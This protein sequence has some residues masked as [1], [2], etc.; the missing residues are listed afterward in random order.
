VY[1]LTVSFLNLKRVGRQKKF[2]TTADVG[3]THCVF[4]AHHL[5]GGL[6][7]IIT[8]RTLAGFVILVLLA[9][10]KIVERS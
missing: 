7:S 5:G 8:Y 2:S 1:P 10:Q 3:N 9:K 6:D 4:S